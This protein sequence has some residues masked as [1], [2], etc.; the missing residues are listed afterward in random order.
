MLD[1]AVNEDKRRSSRHR[2][3]K[4]AKIGFHELHAAIDCVVRDI[5][6]TGARLSIESTIGV[7]EIFFLAINGAPPRKC[8]IVWRKPSQLGVKFL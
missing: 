8:Q 3:F 6:D 1:A 5:S 2:I 7:P 4:A